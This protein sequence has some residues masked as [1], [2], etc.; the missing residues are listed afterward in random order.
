MLKRWSSTPRS[1]IVLLVTAVNIL[2][3]A[4]GVG[5]SVL[6]F[7]R[8][9]ENT[10]PMI[11]FPQ[12]IITVLLA[13]PLS[14]LFGRQ[15]AKPMND[16]IQATKSISKGD[17]S[18]RVDETGRGEIGELLGSFNQMTAELE[19]TEMMRTDFINT[20]SHEFKTPI[21]S[22]RGFAKRLQ[23]G[24]LTQEQQAE[25]LNYIVRQSERLSELSA[26]ILLLCRYENQQMIGAREKYDLDEQVRRCILL[27]ENQWE[28]KNIQ[29][30][31]DL[32][33]LQYEGNE[34]MLDHVW[35]NLIGN[36]V[37]FSPE[38][39]TVTVT[40]AC[41]EHWIEVNV[42]D[43]GIGMSQGEMKHI[44]DK[45]YQSDQA[46]SL[47]GNGLGLPLAKRII[48]LCEGQITVNSSQGAGTEFRVSLPYSSI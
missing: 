8:F 36:A 38:Y 1:M 28:T 14:A 44:F 47:G 11:P 13:I 34:E 15:M 7:N 29:F 19:G 26:N 12:I 39:G 9:P 42:K 16:M 25:Y 46:K 27:L 48:D 40:A 31:I 5:I 21:V 45:F 35:L 4:I 17:Y 23:Q 43:E 41:G 10:I 3:G 22:I 30:D 32:Q 24:N 33:P 37:K 18:I 6:V 2:S 20:F